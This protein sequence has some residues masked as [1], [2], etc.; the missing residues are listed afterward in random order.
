MTPTCLPTSHGILALFWITIKYRYTIPDC[1]S[2][3]VCI[4]VDIGAMA[5]VRLLPHKCRPLEII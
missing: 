4:A 5:V 2:H 1:N 3:Y